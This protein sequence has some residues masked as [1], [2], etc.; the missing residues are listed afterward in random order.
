MKNREAYDIKNIMIVYNLFQ[1]IFSF[2]IFQKAARFWL[3]GNKA[4]Y[5]A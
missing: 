4:A 1:T 5:S 3:S 2:W